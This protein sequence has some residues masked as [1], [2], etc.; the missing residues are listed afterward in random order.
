M[1]GAL[2]VGRLE[3]RRGGFRGGP[4]DFRLEP[5]ESIQLVGPNG[6]GKS[7]LLETLAGLLPAAG[8]TVSLGETTWE[9]PGAPTL[10]PWRRG[11]GVVLQGL[12]L[13]PHLKVAAQAKLVAPAGEARVLD[14]AERL[15]LTDLLDRWPRELSGGEAQRAALLR[16]LAPSP[17]VLILDEPTSAQHEETEALVRAA[18]E[19]EIERGRIVVLAAHRGWVGV[20]R[21]ELDVG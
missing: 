6:S 2:V 11:I 9:G 17:Q 1:S 20:R 16:A 3:I 8:G 21:L 14:L 18:V 5:G 15:R 12:G 10:P 4:F 13:W 7:T 19:I